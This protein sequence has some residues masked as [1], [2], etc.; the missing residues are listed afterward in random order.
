M[1]V[2]PKLREKVEYSL[3]FLLSQNRRPVGIQ[4]SQAR[5]L[6]A[7]DTKT[8][9]MERVFG[10][11]LLPAPFVVSHLQLGLLLQGL[12]APL[13]EKLHER[14]GGV[15][16]QRAQRLESAQGIQ[17]EAHVPGDGGGAGCHRTRQARHDD[18]GGARQSAILRVC[19]REP[20]RRAAAGRAV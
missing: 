13:S 8:A 3:A 5:Q 15:P 20:G 11:E 12:G 14:V 17:A 19:R 7:E 10:F 18:P 16:H 9:A 2:C 4:R 1:V 6:T